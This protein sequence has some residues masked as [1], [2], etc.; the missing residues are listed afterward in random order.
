MTLKENEMKRMTVTMFIP[1]AQ[2][3]LPLLPSALRTEE[4]QLRASGVYPLA[5]ELAGRTVTRAMTQTPPRL[6]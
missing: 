5:E 6:R 1:H 2:R 3:F 4:K